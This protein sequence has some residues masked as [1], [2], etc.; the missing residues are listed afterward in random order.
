MFLW[1]ALSARLE[2]ADLTAPIIFVGIGVVISYGFTLRASVE[3]DIVKLVTEVTLVWLL[4]SDAAKVPL[5]QLR[6]EAAVFGRL[7]AVALPV[8]VTLGWLLAWGLFD[9]FDVWIALLVGA[10]LAPTDAALGA[11]VINNRAV[12]SRIR[13]ILNVESGLNDGI[14]TPVVVLAL[15]GAASSPGGTGH[16]GPAHALLQL[17][18]GA[19]LGAASGLIGGAGLRVS[20]RRG[21]VDEEFAGPAVLAL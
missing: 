15:A 17:L 3:A 8:T 9:G 16:T 11:A 19:L 14:V 10:A 4:F 1:G 2:R 21:W 7:L 12:P 20:R 13:G 18:V 6:A 5:H